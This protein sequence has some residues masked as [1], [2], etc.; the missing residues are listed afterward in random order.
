MSLLT[1]TILLF[2][3]V[4]LLVFGVGGIITYQLVVKEVK[5]ETDYYLHETY[6]ATIG[7]IRAG[8]PIEALDN[9]KVLITKLQGTNW[10]DTLSHY[11]DT[12]AEHFNLHRMEPHRNLTR[13]KEIDGT[14]YR[15]SITDVLI[16]LDDMY[17]GVVGV[18]S[19]LFLYL[20]ASVILGSVIISR[21]LFKPFVQVLNRLSGFNLKSSEGLQVPETSTKEFKK[22]NSFLLKM[23]DKAQRDYRSLKEFTENASHEMQTPIA[24]AKGKLELMLESPDLDEERAELIQ[25]AYQAISRLSSI[26]HS[27]TLLSKIENQE[28]TISGTIN[29]SQLL[30]H[31][32]DNFRELAELKGICLEADIEEKVEL[33]IENSLADILVSNL[34]KNAIQHNQ[35]EGWIKVKLTPDNLSI[36]NTGPAPT[37]DT[38]LL[39]ERFKKG[40]QSGGSLGLGLSIVKKIVEVCDWRVSYQFAEEIHHLQVDFS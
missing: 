12:L 13:I 14:F 7:G 17:E 9:E 35:A 24:V 30:Q 1:K 6:K 40:N 34:I 19:R 25:G 39:F 18:L 29:F 23:T 28:F 2:L 5:V 8:K 16:E 11:K 33:P 37:V 22:L 38:S 4:A 15:I 36:K 32:I 3:V 20:S 31:A 10:T 26:G 27:L 21:W